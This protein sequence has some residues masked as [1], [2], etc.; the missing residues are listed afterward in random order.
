MGKVIGWLAAGTFLGLVVL[1]AI[2]RADDKHKEDHFTGWTTDFSAEKADLVSTGRNPCFSL[3]PGYFLILEK[4]D[5]QLTITVRDETK[6]V[7]GVECRVVEENETKGGKVEEKSKNY[8]AISKR[9]N[10]VFYFGEDVGGAWLSGEKGARF[11]LMI[12]GTPLLKARYYQE[13]A[14]GVA[15]D[16]AEIVSVTETVVTPAG[17]FTNCLKTEETTPLHPK[18]KEYKY[19]APGVGLVQEGELKLVKYGKAKETK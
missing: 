12:P 1:G 7:D 2:T 9:T 8:L 6:K 13:I 14:P 10:S 4:G 11:G 16:R 18:E 19:Y 17:T 15:L 5:T 3:E